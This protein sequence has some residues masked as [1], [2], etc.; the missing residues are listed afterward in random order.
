MEAQAD[1]SE[2]EILSV[3]R[4]DPHETSLLIKVGIALPLAT[5]IWQVGAG[6]V[7]PLVA[8]APVTIALMLVYGAVLT[9]MTYR[10]I[11]AHYKW[12]IE[13][14]MQSQRLAATR[15]GHHAPEQPLLLKDVIAALQESQAPA[16]VME[17]PFHEAYFLLRL[18]EEV[19][20]CRRE[21]LK[22]SVVVMDVTAPGGTKKPELLEKVAFD[23]AQL[24]S[25]QSKTISL[26]LQTG[27]TEFAFAL[28]HADRNEAK[29][30]ISKLISALGEYWCHY[31]LSVYP[32][33]AT[34]AEGLLNIAR[35]SCQE[36][37]EGH[38]SAPV[39]T[40]LGALLKR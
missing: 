24:A 23:V 14:A 22:L 13:S 26:A 25:K 32:E 11:R 4:R 2:N 33:D 16:H 12:Q 40:R 1:K 39:R 21:G 3:L 10:L 18:Q 34:D 19:L 15:D 28:P 17:G 36:S 37:R 30:Y 35:E 8:V 6:L 31:G 20:R 38:T 5:I 9:Y 27:E 7:L 29:P